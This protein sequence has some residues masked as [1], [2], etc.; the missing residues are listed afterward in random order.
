MVGDPLGGWANSQRGKPLKGLRML[1]QTCPDG[2]LLG[3]QD[4]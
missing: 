3:P 1:L 2:F 4:L